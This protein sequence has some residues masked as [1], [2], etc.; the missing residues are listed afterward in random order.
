MGVVISITTTDIH[1]PDQVPGTVL[2]PPAPS[3][4]PGARLIRAPEL[5]EASR[6]LD[7]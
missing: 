7:L 6:G 4:E 3:S 2:E 1:G 5:Q